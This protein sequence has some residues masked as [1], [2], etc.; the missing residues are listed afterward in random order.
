LSKVFPNG[1]ATDEIE[2]RTNDRLRKGDVADRIEAGV[3]DELAAEL[4]EGR[5]LG[6]VL[7]PHD[8]PPTNRVLMAAE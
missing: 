8:G 2:R 5:G 7:R 4:I 6:L 3:I 1:S